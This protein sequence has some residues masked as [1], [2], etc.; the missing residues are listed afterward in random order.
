MVDLGYGNQSK[1]IIRMAAKLVCFK[2][3]IDAQIIDEDL[4]YNQN[5]VVRN[6]NSALTLGAELIKPSWQRKTVKQLGQLGLW[7]VIKDT[8]YRD[9]FFW[10]LYQVLKRADKLLVMIEPYVKPP[11][12]WTPNVWKDS[13]L[14]TK[15]LKDTGHIGANAMCL[16]ETIFTPNIQNKRQKEL[17][18]KRK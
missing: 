12:E 1:K 9:A 17:L 10:I 18:K 13:K 11:E 3:N 5:Q 2:L 6:L 7:I 15:K 8:A 4:K 14:K 16:E